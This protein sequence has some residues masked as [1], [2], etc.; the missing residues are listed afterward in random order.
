MAKGKWIKDTCPYA[1]DQGFYSVI[2]DV[3]PGE[4]VFGF[5]VTT[6]STDHSC[7][8]KTVTEGKVV[9]M[10]DT[11]YRVI[12]TKVGAGSVATVPIVKTKT[13]TS[14]NI[15]GENAKVYDVIVIGRVLY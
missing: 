13:K 4:T 2:G 5:S 10:D 14:F 1:K 11:N 8:L 15:A 3:R 12:A 7:V 9:Q 6:G